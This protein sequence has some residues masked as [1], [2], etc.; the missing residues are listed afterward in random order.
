MLSDKN[1]PNTTVIASPNHPGSVTQVNDDDQVSS[2]RYDIEKDALQVG[3]LSDCSQVQGISNATTLR[4][5]GNDEQTHLLLDA[6]E[7]SLA[8]HIEKVNAVVL[9]RNGTDE[10]MGINIDH[11]Q[12]VKELD[13]NMMG[14]NNKYSSAFL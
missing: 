13:G 3:S 1:M 8:T 14:V 10:M 5:S 6:D 4:P 7:T 11:A 12:M 2:I 9:G